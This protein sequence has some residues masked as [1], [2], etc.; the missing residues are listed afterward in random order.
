[1]EGN[2]SAA[3]K[4]QHMQ[5]YHANIISRLSPAGFPEWPAASDLWSIGVIEMQLILSVIIKDII[6][7]INGHEERSIHK[8]KP[9]DLVLL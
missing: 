1:M 7:N 4:P 2:F 6:H 5:I 9:I 8:P 3:N